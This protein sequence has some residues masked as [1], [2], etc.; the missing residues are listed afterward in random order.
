MTPE[1]LDGLLNALRDPTINGP[2]LG[3]VE[4]SD[5]TFTGDAGF[6]NA[7]FTSR[8][9]FA[10]VTFSGAASFARATFSGLAGFRRAMFTGRA[11]FEK[12]TFADRALFGRVT[13]SGAAVFGRVRFSGD[14]E[15]RR[16]TFIRRAGFERAMFTDRAFFGGAT[17][18][19]AGRFFGAAFDATPQL[20]PLVCKEGL[21]LSGAVFSVPVTIEAAAAHLLCRRTRWASTASLRLRYATVDLSYAVVEYPL[22]VTS[23]SSPLIDAERGRLDESSLAGRDAGVRMTSL[24]G[25]DASHLVLTDVDLAACR[26]TGTI[27]LD[28]LS[29]EGRCT[30][31][32]API[33]LHRQGWRLIRRTPRRT[34]AEEHY[35]RTARGAAGWTPAPDGAES[36]G[37]E[38]LAPV[39][40]QLRKSLEDGKNEPDA[41]DFYYGEMEMRR[42]DIDRPF[43]ERAL[44]TVYWAISGYGLRASRAMGW[45][46][47]AMTVTLLG[48]MLW[49]L[50][51]EAPKPEST[52]RL[53]GQRITLTTV[54][55]DPVAPD[56]SLH[57]RITTERFD[58]ALRVL[59][60]SVVFR[61]SDQ[62]LTN[63]G[64]YTE[65]ASRVT[66]PVLL[67][68]AVLAIRGRV[69]R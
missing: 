37:P 55:R 4:F 52:G 29:L 63:A 67:G 53:T 17:F 20:G 35:W 9:W 32:P 36:V 28:R 14:A 43:A 31:A 64:A 46:L 38:A 54:A 44:L 19:S 34:L 59:I 61:S 6:E 47:V 10:G 16:A 5:A 30:F 45:L 60:N 8:A 69:K 1:L 50:P 42:H 41:A 24:S 7:A 51:R 2:R 11:R 21:D 48:L 25:V 33:G 62:G 56:N 40:R 3:A 12:A 22:S 26:F 27:H 13:F 65:M 18:A 39:Y 68:L 49:G 58:E 23:Q 15:F 66:E 57:E